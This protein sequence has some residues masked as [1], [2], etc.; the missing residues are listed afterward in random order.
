MKKI[1]SI[2]SL[3]LL[4]LV[5]CGREVQNEPY[6]G[7]N[8]VF[9]TLTDG[10]KSLMIDGPRSQSVDF[11]IR[12]TS[13]AKSN[14]EFEVKLSGKGLSDFKTESP[15]RITI[16][17]GQFEAQFSLTPSIRSLIDGERTLEVGLVSSATTIELPTTPFVITI[18]TKPE[19]ELTERD[20][21]LIT[22]YR[23]NLGVDI[24]PLLGRQLCDG[25][26]SWAG[27]KEGDYD[28]PKLVAE[29]TVMVEKQVMTVGLSKKATPT[30]II[31]KFKHNALGQN[32][33]MR[34]LWEYLTIY[35]EAYWNNPDPVYQQ[36]YPKLIREKINWTKETAPKE[37][38]DVQ[39][40]NV[41]L[42]PETGEILFTG[43][44]SQSVQYEDYVYTEVMEE[45]MTVIPFHFETSVWRRMIE[46]AK[47]DPLFLEQ[48]YG[49]DINI[50][51]IL[52]NEGIKR[53]MLASEGI[54]QTK[55]FKPV[56][57]V[58]FKTHTMTFDYPFYVRNSDRYSGTHIK[59]KPMTP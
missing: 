7:K 19:V 4:T 14:I 50:Y 38:F 49:G 48:V 33:F 17:K 59:T 28:Y 58:D 31:L 41:R 51:E 47:K 8:K 11:H 27:F 52:N 9:L 35:D 40:D 26:I 3:L 12:L 43:P 6:Q 15:I 22:A 54:K 16:A 21:E 55:Y 34:E 44:L 36:P 46:E 30:K 10:T 13:P 1:L 39:L 37:T 20:K 29:R 42:N 25:E 2:F 45:T 24:L 23:E 5:S 57:K 18:K 32:T 56:G 53:D